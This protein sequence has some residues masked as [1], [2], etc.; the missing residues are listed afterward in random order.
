MHLS[1][2]HQGAPPVTHI[3]SSAPYDV[4]DLVVVTGAT[5]NFFDRTTNMIGSVHVWEPNQRIVVYDLGY[6]N[7]QV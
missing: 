2:Y 1:D 6:T 5:A 3:D 4:S 7:E